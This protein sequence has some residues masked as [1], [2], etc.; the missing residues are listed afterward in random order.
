M[1]E[2]SN[3]QVAGQQVVKD[4]SYRYHYQWDKPN[5]VCPHCLD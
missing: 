2:Q 5:Q 1:H 3:V 4:D